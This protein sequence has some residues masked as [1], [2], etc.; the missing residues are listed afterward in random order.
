MGDAPTKRQRKEC[1]F[2]R[3]KDMEIEA[4]TFLAKRIGNSHRK[5]LAIGAFAWP[6]VSRAI[7]GKGKEVSCKE[8]DGKAF[9]DALK[10]GKFG[11]TI[12][13]AFSRSSDRGDSNLRPTV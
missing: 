11:S 6:N 9:N 4:S 7:K 2:L 10:Q 3:D 1:S 13:F 12:N 8:K 5:Q